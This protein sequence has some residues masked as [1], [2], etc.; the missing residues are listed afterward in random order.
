[1]TETPEK[2]LT[3]KIQHTLKRFTNTKKLLKERLFLFKHVPWFYKTYLF[4]RKAL[5]TQ[6]ALSKGKQVVFFLV[7]FSFSYFCWF[8]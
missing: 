5:L 3:T 8:F 7:A 2:F 1:M 4:L 6:S